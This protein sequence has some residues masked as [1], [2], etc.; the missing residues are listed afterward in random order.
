MILSH[1]CGYKCLKHFNIDEVCKN[2]TD[3]YPDTVF[4]NRFVELEQ[5]VAIPFHPV[6]EEVL[7]WLLHGHQLRG[8]HGLF[9]KLF[10]DGLRL[11]TK[12][13]SNMKG[14]ISTISDRVLLCKRAL[15]P[16]RTN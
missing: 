15:R 11:V 7:H 10:V 9:S 4:Y 14:Q 5:K 8:Q 2:M 1:L 16:S 6:R 13:K 12:L 3:L